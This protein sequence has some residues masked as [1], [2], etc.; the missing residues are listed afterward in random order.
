MWLDLEVKVIERP[1]TL[2]FRPGCSTPVTSPGSPSGMTSLCCRR[3]AWP[4]GRHRLA[5][6]SP[7]ESRCT[8]PP[9]PWGRVPDPTAPGLMGSMPP[10]NPTTSYSFEITV[11]DPGFSCLSSNP[12]RGAMATFQKIMYIKMKT[13]GYHFTLRCLLHLNPPVERH[14]PWVFSE[15]CQFCQKWILPIHQH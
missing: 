12:L 2:T 6:G 4:A 15:I 3:I 13:S 5:R 11:A 10:R 8:L 14:C 9:H 1:W 7:A